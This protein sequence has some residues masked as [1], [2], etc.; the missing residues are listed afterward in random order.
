M[1]FFQPIR[2]GH[3]RISPSSNPEYRISP[4]MPRDDWKKLP[5]W[6]AAFSKDNSRL[7]RML[8]CAGMTTETFLWFDSCKVAFRCHF[9]TFPIS[10]TIPVSVGCSRTYAAVSSCH[11]AM[12]SRFVC[13]RRA[14]TRGKIAAEYKSAFFPAIPETRNMAD[15]PNPQNQIL[16][17]RRLRMVQENRKTNEKNKKYFPVQISGKHLFRNVV[18]FGHWSEP[19]WGTLGE[20][21]GNERGDRI[22]GGFFN[23]FSGSV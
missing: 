6:N 20:G 14:A 8:C 22:C 1:E 16:S 12:E 2:Y 17:K 23:G 9:R 19:Y 3:S 5:V 7:G 11:S 10:M 4:M 18:H 21:R 13:N 15:I